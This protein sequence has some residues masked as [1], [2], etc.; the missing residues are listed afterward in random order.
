MATLKNSEKEALQELIKFANKKLNE[1]ERNLQA[2]KSA[3]QI[4]RDLIYITYNDYELHNERDIQELYGAGVITEHR[5]DL[6]L[7]ELDDK[8][9]ASSLDYKIE[10]QE[11]I[12]K[13]WQFFKK[14]LDDTLNW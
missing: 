8:I 7:K 14:S 11:Q 10:K 1:A 3:N 4:A 6:L 2:I 9:K 12:I 13:C 5:Y